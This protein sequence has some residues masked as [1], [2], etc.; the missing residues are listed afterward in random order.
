[1]HDLYKIGKFFLAKITAQPNTGSASV[2]TPHM[3]IILD[4]S[5][6]M[7]TFVERS[8]EGIQAA[9]L[10]LGYLPTERVTLITFDSEAELYNL[11]VQN[12][13]RQNIRSRGSTRF[14]QV[15]EILDSVFG[16]K[17]N[18]RIICVSDG[19]IDDQNNAMNY[20]NCLK[21]NHDNFVYNVLCI[22]LFTG[23]SSTPDTRVLTG[24]AQLNNSGSIVNIDEIRQDQNLIQSIKDLSKSKFNDSLG[25]N[26]VMESDSLMA[27]LPWEE[28]KSKVTLGQSENYIWFDKV[29]TITLINDIP[30]QLCEETITM[31]I[32]EPFIKRVENQIRVLH[33]VNTTDSK[34]KLEKIKTYLT[35]FQNWVE[36]MDTDDIVLDYTLQ[37]RRKLI[38]KQI[39]S[40]N[41]SIFT[42]LQELANMDTVSK[43]NQNQQ[44]EFLRSNVIATSKAK[45][46]VKI[47]GGNSSDFDLDSR[48]RVDV[49]NIC[50]NISELDHI[51]ADNCDASY[52]SQETCIESLRNLS[53][54]LPQIDQLTATDIFKLVNIVGLGAFCKIQEYPD[55]R[56]WQPMEIYP[57]CII[58]MADIITHNQMKCSSRQYNPD[59]GIPVPALDNKVANCVIPMFKDKEV[60]EFLCRNAPTLLEV[61][62]SINIMRLNL[63]IPDSFYYTM[64][65]G[66]Y[67]LIK[68]CIINKK[69]T[70][71]VYDSIKTIASNINSPKYIGNYKKLFSVENPTLNMTSFKQV[72]NAIVPISV[73][74]QNDF[75]DT[76]KFLRATF[77]LIAYHNIKGISDLEQECRKILQ[78][79]LSKLDY[80]LME[81]FTEN[82][83]FKEVP[84]SIEDKIDGL[85]VS[86]K[87]VFL[88]MKSILLASQ[89]KKC[90]TPEQLTS[91]IEDIDTK[92]CGLYDV[93]Y[94]SPKVYGAYQILIS[95]LFN[96]QKSRVDVD[97]NIVLVPDF[98]EEND[99]RTYFQKYVNDVYRE[100]YDRKIKEKKTNENSILFTILADTIIQTDNKANVI[101]LLRNGKVDTIGNSSVT[102]K[103]INQNSEG[104]DYL[105]N[106]LLDDTIDVPLRAYKIRIVILGTDEK[107]QRVW[108]GNNIIRGYDY[109][110]CM[111]FF[112]KAEWEDFKSVMG[113]YKRHQYRASGKPNRRGHSNSNPSFFG[114]G[115]DTMEQFL[116]MESRSEIIKYIKIWKQA[117]RST[118]SSY[119]S[120]IEATL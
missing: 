72:T 1:M 58:S 81:P 31:D 14:S 25:I 59:D 108:N 16:S 76:P 3:I 38:L 37:N 60:Y 118:Q 90:G 94:S 40:R 18:C 50:Q 119:Y 17:E 92:M 42:K 4:R 43:M 51:Q 110:K 65:N 84:F 97:N 30:I 2:Q 69:C 88:H 6:S 87:R 106:S 10:D 47:A 11:D 24:I 115:Y 35:S 100:E 96:T 57:H 111:P 52:F 112:D 104:V 70:E 41:K 77:G 117:E 63:D 28:F 56:A 53:T 33:I 15:P 45:R 7:G 80:L 74:V 5:G 19:E 95:L 101:N 73:L 48:V 26:M 120:N 66:M 62:S 13:T 102:T 29:P 103:F 105:I 93:N 20:I 32:L 44:A 91:F 86:F 9:L 71:N 83:P 23:Y 46:L 79:D 107:Y 89:I 85:C 12:L 49:H 113:V 99:A 109:K 34:E 98:Q 75:N 27:Q 8:L 54:I 36:S 39:Q 61:I 67:S 78:I 22:R 114:L 82:I 68:S 116:Q 64:A 55:A 21:K